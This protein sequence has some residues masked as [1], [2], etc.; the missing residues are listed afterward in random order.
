MRRR[1]PSRL[2]AAALFTAVFVIALPTPGHAQFLKKLKET[3]QQAAEEEAVSQVDLF[4][5]G[6]VQCVFNDLECIEGAA[7]SGEDYVLTGPDGEVI[8]DEDGV[9]VSDQA[10]AY[11]IMGV[12]NEAG[13]ADLS[14]MQTGTTPGLE[15]ADANF[16]FEPG[17][18]VLFEDDFADDN[19]GDFPRRWNFRKGNWDIVEWNGAR[20]LRNTGPRGAAVDIPLPDN[21]PEK[22]TIEF[23]AFFPHTNQHM[24]VA[25][26]APPSG[27]GFNQLAGNVAQVGV[28]GS[29]TGIRALSATATEAMTNSKEVAEGPVPIRIMVDGQYAK[30]FVGSRRVANVPNAEFER[31]DRIY[32]ENV[33]FAD[34]KNPMLIGS[35][36]IA[37]GGRDLYDVLAAE[38]RF[39]ARGIQFEVSSASIRSESAA[40]LAEIGTMLREHPELRLSIEGHT[41]SEG[42]DQYNL[43]LSRQRATAVVD[44]LVGNFG[45]E[46]S[47]LEAIGFGETA[48]VASNDTPD[49]RAQNRRV[50]LVRR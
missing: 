4:V 7:A 46:A 1:A 11:E 35:I 37:A 30:M 17:D 34:A 49:G 18:L 29:R 32:F 2:L 43:M 16:D 6:K 15:E 5:R 42:D 12:A 39:T 14:T 40:I 33:Y 44:Y 26:S 41:D 27:K 24:V 3:A 19:V 20:W 36:R 10:E 38:G 45:I 23:E 9:P 47:R 25:T 22:F 28:G 21:L 31:G 50:E 8:V 48:P 13:P